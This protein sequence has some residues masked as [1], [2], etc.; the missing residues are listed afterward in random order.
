MP[1]NWKSIL[2]KVGTYI[3]SYREQI[4]TM[5]LICFGALILARGRIGV[6]ASPESEIRWIEVFA[7]MPKYTGWILIWYG[8][9][10]LFTKGKATKYILDKTL[11]PVLNPIIKAIGSSIFGE[12]KFSSWIERLNKVKEDKV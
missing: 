9:D 7:L 11:V 4:D 10:N 3:P 6:Q 2:N 5:V 12:K 1:S 8:L